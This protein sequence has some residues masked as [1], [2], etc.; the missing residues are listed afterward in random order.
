M[1]VY[2]DIDYT[3]H[4]YTEELVRVAKEIYGIEVDGVQA[5]KNSVQW[6]LDSLEKDYRLTVPMIKTLCRKVDNSGKWNP[7]EWQ[8]RLVNMIKIFC[9]FEK[10]QLRI[11]SARQCGRNVVQKMVGSI[12]GKDIPVILCNSRTKPCVIENG[13]VYFEDHAEVANEVG[14]IKPDCKV[15]VPQWPWNEKK[16]VITENVNFLDKEVV[17]YYGDEKNIM[18]L[19]F[20]F[21]SDLLGLGRSTVEKTLM[22]INSKG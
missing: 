12:F 9:N 6:P 10:N 22:K 15:F 17:W 21:F 14:R 1:I 18:N 4:Y 7:L 11:I 5:E 19:D 3:I 16:L 20:L 13:S 2:C 8:S